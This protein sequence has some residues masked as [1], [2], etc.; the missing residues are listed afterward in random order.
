MRGLTLAEMLVCC[1]VI[2]VVAAFAAPAA[3]RLFSA[4]ALSS[5]VNLFVEDAAF[6]RSEAL[7]R[8]ISVTMC[9]STDPLASQPRCADEAEQGGWHTG[10]IVFVD[11][12]GDRQRAASEPVLRVQAAL[13]RSRLVTDDD[14]H[15]DRLRYL[16]TGWAPGPAATLRFVPAEAGATEHGASRAVCVSPLGRV[17]VLAPRAAACV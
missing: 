8:G 4:Q 17:Q 7:R 3:T 15:L 10:W 11:A 12:N 16:P 14:A 1:A 5:E 6:T 2:G 13:A 9:R